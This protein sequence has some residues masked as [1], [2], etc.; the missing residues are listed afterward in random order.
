MEYSA[1]SDSF[2]ACPEG[3]KEFYNQRRRW[4]PSTLANIMDLLSD[5]KRVIKNND[6]ISFFYIIYQIMLMVGTCLGPGSIMLMLSGAFSIAFGLT[7][8]EAFIAN[9]LPVIAF[10]VICF[11]C[12]SDI[13]LAVA[14]FLSVVYALVMV[15]MVIG[16][17][18][19]ASEDG[20][21]AP[22]SLSLIY[23]V[24]IFLLAGILHPQEANCLPMGVIYLLTIPSM[25][26]LLV[27]YSVFNL[28]NVSWGTRYTH[29]KNIFTKFSLPCDGVN[30]M[31]FQF[32]I[33]SYTYCGEHANMI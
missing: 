28:N 11:T 7:D 24:F 5:Y 21:S 25:Y 22:T 1:A 18:I 8:T 33:A 13:Q 15:A 30:E 14:E 4:M 29:H 26:L 31:L 2:T 3:F 12:K 27:I 17:I 32:E 6:D 20:G 16:I 19:S 23:T 9:S 10:I